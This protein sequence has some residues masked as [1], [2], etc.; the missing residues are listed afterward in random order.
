MPQKPRLRLAK[1]QGY[2]QKKNWLLAKRNCF[3]KQPQL[4][5]FRVP[6]NA[7][8]SPIDSLVIPANSTPSAELPKLKRYL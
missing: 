4:E 7:T 5:W 8:P 2:E 1:Q 6:K 3:V